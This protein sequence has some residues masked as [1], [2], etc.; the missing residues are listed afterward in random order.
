MPAHLAT[1]LLAQ[2][3]AAAP[4]AAPP[5][6]A[7]PPLWQVLLDNG[8]ALS[9]LFIFLVAIVSVVVNQRRRDKCLRLLHGYRVSSIAAV[10][11][12]VWGELIVYAK[13]LELVFDRP[14]TTRR[15]LVKAS[16]VLYPPEVDG[17]LCLARAVDALTPE[18]RADRQR[19]IDRSF[20]P[21]LLRRWLRS[22]RNI[23]ATLRD[24]F[25]KSLSAILGTFASR[26]R[27]GGVLATQQSSIHS[28]GDTLLGAAANAY[29]PILERHIGRPVILQ[30]LT[31]GL[32]DGKFVELPGYLV[33][34][35]AQYVAVFN[36]THEPI[37]STTIDVAT[38]AAEPI[39]AGGLTIERG[40]E[41]VTLK[42]T[43]PEAVVVSRFSTPDRTAEVNAVLV[44]GSSLD[45]RHDNHAVQI[46]SERTRRLDWVA[47]RSRATIYFGSDNPTGKDRPAGVAPEENVEAASQ[48]AED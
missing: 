37:E 43:G 47:P 36:T 11:T 32:G 33:D 3:E 1:L 40:P 10:G 20:K 9:I 46:A 48:P 14:H 6:P 27:P 18:E 17:L 16:A 26:A 29:E 30:L 23:L 45:F 5:A 15:G 22:I 41:C 21:N 39:V 13:G 42:C 25:S 38:D 34:Y 4:A 31:P 19:Q 8:L 2:A 24:A 7:S 44:P 28:I 12:L 35:S